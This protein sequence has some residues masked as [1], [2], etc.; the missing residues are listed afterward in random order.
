MGKLLEALSRPSSYRAKKTDIWGDIIDRIEG[1]LLPRD[2]DDIETWLL[3]HELDI[4][5]AWEPEIAELLEKRRDELQAED[6]GQ[7]LRD[8]F[9]F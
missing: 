3:A 5:G 4:P 2:L 7:I 9:D 8:R 1:A 6:V